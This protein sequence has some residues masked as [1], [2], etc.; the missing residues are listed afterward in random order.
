M[1]VSLIVAVAENSVIGRDNEL[2]WR[3]PE[4]LRYFKRVTMGKPVIMGRKTFASIGRPLPGRPNI[5]VTRDPGWSAEGVDAVRSVDDA[6]ALAGR[7]ASGGEVMIIGGAQLFAATSGVADRLYLTEIH[8]RYDGDVFF[9]QPDPAE[10][11]ETSRE[12]HPG[13][14]AFSFVVLERN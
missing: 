5:V 10:W 14:P 4:D 2:P 7:L 12:D 13:D 9:P 3:I 8:A 1:R 11:R 6:L